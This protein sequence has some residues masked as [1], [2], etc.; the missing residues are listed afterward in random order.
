MKTKY[1]KNL[2]KWEKRDAIMDA[3][4]LSFVHPIKHDYIIPSLTY[5]NEFIAKMIGDVKMPE[6]IKQKLMEYIYH[7]NEDYSRLESY[8]RNSDYMFGSEWFYGYGD[9]YRWRGGQRELAEKRVSKYVT[10]TEQ[11]YLK[12]I[13][14]NIRTITKK[15]IESFEMDKVFVI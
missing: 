7:R 15:T 6:K 3:I 14:E 9:L 8:I 11:K 2:E 13:S 12:Q 10:K 4:L 5:L 1:N